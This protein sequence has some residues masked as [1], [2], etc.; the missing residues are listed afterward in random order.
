METLEQR[1][2]RL[3]EPD[4]DRLSRTLA[5][6]AEVYAT[7]YAAY[8]DRG[9]ELTKRP[10]WQMREYVRGW[11]TAW[12]LHRLD[13]TYRGSVEVDRIITEYTEDELLETSAEGDIES[14][15]SPDLDP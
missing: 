14:D 8:P 4:R 11:I 9:G 5:N 2:Y 3:P 10:G 15:P 6:L 7:A 13:P 12:D 1:M